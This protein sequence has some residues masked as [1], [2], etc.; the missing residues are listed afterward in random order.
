GNY[1][2]SESL[3]V[4]GEARAPQT[5]G[6]GGRYSSYPSYGGG[7]LKVVA[8]TA[9]S[10]GGSEANGVSGRSSSTGGGAGGS[11]W[12]EIGALRLGKTARIE[13]KGANSTYGGGGGGGRVALYYSSLLGAD[14]VAAT[15]VTGGS[16][17][18]MA[19]GAGTLY[20]Q[21]VT[22]G[23]QFLRVDN[24]SLR[25]GNWTEFTALPDGL[26][27]LQLVNSRVKLQV[28]AV[29]RL[30]LDNAEVEL[31]VPQV[32]ELIARNNSLVF[33]GTDQ[34]ERLEADQ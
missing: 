24:G 17:G 22:R 19:G 16:G 25:A 13:A 2:N 8:T 27:E 20:W 32:P 14:L 7:A 34:I 30:V 18:S 12:L 33:L 4:Y 1:S 9:E 29:P 28:E 23:E 10:D 11:V 5:L 21:D 3:P 26:T 31:T 15:K 6:Q